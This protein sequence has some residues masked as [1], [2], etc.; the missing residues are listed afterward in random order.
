MNNTLLQLFH[1]IIPVSNELEQR[2]S[3]ALQTKTFPKKY[4]LLKEGQVC[5]YI[6]FIEKGFLRSYYINHE[7]ETTDWFMKENDIIIS[8]NSFFKIEP[9]YEFIQTIEESA[10]H[11]VHYDELQKIYKEF[12]EFNIVG[13]VLTEMYYTLSEERLYGMRSQTAKERFAFLLD[14][15]PEIIQRSPVGYIA[16]YLGISLETLS[17]LRGKK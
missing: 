17:R 5:N 3:A 15:H 8:V 10:L 12:V 13:R 6:Y 16:S 1:S 7:K 9:S 4:L 2:L 14:K 11:Y